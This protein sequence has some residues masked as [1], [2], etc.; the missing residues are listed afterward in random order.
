LVAVAA[1]AGGLWWQF[2]DDVEDLDSEV[3]THPAPS[4]SE[5]DGGSLDE[6]STVG[7]LEE[8]RASLAY[9]CAGLLDSLNEG[10]PGEDWPDASEAAPGCKDALDR[11]FLGAPTSEP[12]L[13]LSDSPTWDRVFE[14]ASEKIALVLDTF[15]NELCEVPLGE[16]RPELASACGATAAVD[17]ALLALVCTTMHSEPLVN[18]ST[19]LPVGVPRE[20]PYDHFLSRVL[21]GDLDVLVDRLGA[22]SGDQ[23]SYWENRQRVEELYLRTAW[24]KDKCTPR[25]KVARAILEDPRLTPAALIQRAARL[26]NDFALAHYDPVPKDVEALMRLHPIQAYIHL[27][28]QESRRFYGPLPSEF[29]PKFEREAIKFV[30]AAELVAIEDDVPLNR[31]KL[32]AI[33]NPDE[34]WYLGSDGL[35]VARLEAEALAAEIRSAR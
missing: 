5:A 15:D 18:S 7:K 29:R 32:Y 4:R 17:L 9:E 33:A 35:Q 16:I 28:R 31:Q 3:A 21:P 8:D 6:R 26:G 19:G 24:A 13:L 10:A 1:I 2:R 27:A 23:E 11:R 20:S 14:G 22:D 30:L 34:P 12:I 25:A